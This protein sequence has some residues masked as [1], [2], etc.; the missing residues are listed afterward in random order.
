MLQWFS[1]IQVG[2][3]HNGKIKALDLTLYNNAGSSLD[4]SKMVSI[5]LSPIILEKQKVKETK[6]EKDYKYYGTEK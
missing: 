2:F 6:L 3:W 1:P 5:L 4:E